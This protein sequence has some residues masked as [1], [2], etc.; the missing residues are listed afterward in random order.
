MHMRVPGPDRRFAALHDSG[1]STPTS[2]RHAQA[3]SGYSSRGLATTKGDDRADCCSR[4]RHKGLASVRVRRDHDASRPPL[5]I[6]IAAPFSSRLSRHRPSRLSNAAECS[7]LLT[8]F[9]F[10]I[11]WRPSP[12]SVAFRMLT[13]TGWWSCGL[14]SAAF[15]PSWPPNADPDIA[16]PSFVPLPLRPGGD[17]RIFEPA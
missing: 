1:S 2:G 7:Y 16:L 11:S 14:P 4:H 12:I 15:K 17:H 6:L 10:R 5:L 8:R 13:R 3:V 9:I